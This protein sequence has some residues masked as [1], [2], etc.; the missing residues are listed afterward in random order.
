MTTEQCE[1][2]VGFLVRYRCRNHAV[3]RCSR[4][5][6]LACEKHSTGRKKGL[7]CSEC[8]EELDAG[9]SS[10]WSSDDSSFFSSYGSGAPR[11]GVVTNAEPITTPNTSNSDA[12]DEKDFAAFDPLDDAQDD[13]F[14]DLS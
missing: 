11:S 8:E 5:N 10:D 14:S 6:R 2:R 13:D 3:G 7:L 9:T 1:M 12:F 4:C